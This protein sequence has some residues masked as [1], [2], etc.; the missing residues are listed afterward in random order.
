MKI[1]LKV[2]SA[3]VLAAVCFWT[4]GLFG[5][6]CRHFLG[7]TALSSV[8]AIVG[9]FC[10]GLGIGFGLVPVMFRAIDRMEF[11]NHDHRDGSLGSL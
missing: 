8:I 5:G 3:V 4:A 7:P 2:I 11:E 1:L 10:I 9:G 6:A